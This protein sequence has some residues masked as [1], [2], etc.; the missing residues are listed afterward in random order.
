MKNQ[1]IKALFLDVGG[2]LMTNGWDHRLRKLTAET[3]GIEYAEMTDHHGL[4]FDTFETGK[5]TFDEYLKRIIFYKERSFSIDEVKE[6]VFEAVRPFPEMIDFI[7]ELKKN[8]HLKVGIISNEG[9][10]LAIDRIR[11]FQLGDFVDFFI[12]S[13]FVHFRKPDLDIYRLAIDTSQIPPSQTI[14]IDDR[15]LL[16]EIAKGVGLNAIHHT[17]LE[18]TRA[19]LKMYSLQ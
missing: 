14:Y 1:V 4:V 15:Y 10:E 8:Y 19:A 11:R 9:R 2:V 7:K 17:N 13:S 18:T 16:T 5:L 6:F 3:F 12:M